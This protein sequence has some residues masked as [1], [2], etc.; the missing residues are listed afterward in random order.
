MLLM[1]GFL[2][3]GQIKYNAV[4]AWAMMFFL[5]FVFIHL[6]SAFPNSTGEVDIVALHIKALTGAGLQVKDIA[7][8]APYNLQVRVK[9]DRSLSE[10]I[11]ML[12]SRFLSI[13]IFL[14]TNYIINIIVK[15]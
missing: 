14:N 1:T 15:L 6:H 7:V 3:H 5:N 2:V 8:I 13:V 4:A 9:G 11:S 12:W 10:N